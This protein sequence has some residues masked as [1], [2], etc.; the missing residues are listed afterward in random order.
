MKFTAEPNL[1]VRFS[2][3]FV[4]R[5]TG[6]KGIHFDEN[7]QY[8]TEN[9]FEIKILEQHFTITSNSNEENID[10]DIL[11]F[12]EEKTPKNGNTQAK[13]GRK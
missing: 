11:P 10:N 8:E 7:G 6:K 1:F 9:E 12:E 5:M 4:Q 3:K 2:N 13:R